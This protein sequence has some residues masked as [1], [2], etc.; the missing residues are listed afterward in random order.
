MANII[1]IATGGGVF[2]QEEREAYG[3]EEDG[4]NGFE[5]D[6]YEF[7][8]A[9][10]PEEVAVDEVVVAEPDVPDGFKKR[11]R[12][13]PA[14]PKAPRKPR[15]PKEPTGKVG[16]GLKWAS[17]EDECLAEAWKTV[18]IDPF[19]G[20][21]QN[22]DTYWKRV[23]AAYEERRQMDPYFQGLDKE[24]NDSAMSHRWAVIQHACNKWHD[25]QEEVR[26]V[27]VSGTN[28]EDQVRTT[29][30]PSLCMLAG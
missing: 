25:V 13:R 27:H 11:G 16:R 14:A 6:A 1:N 26:R 21:N 15:E 28:A 18:S 7:A 10:E 29:R 5:D 4:H 3:E 20:A 19:T 24:R 2:T 23:K 30:R 9:Q 22:N 17:R 8:E 12:G